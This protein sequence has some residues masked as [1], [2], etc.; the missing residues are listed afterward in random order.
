MRRLLVPALVLAFP[1]IAAGG[2]DAP[3]ADRVSATSSLAGR[4]TPNDRTLLT[5]EA[6]GFRGELGPA[7]VLDTSRCSTTSYWVL[8]VGGVAGTVP[9]SVT[10]GIRLSASHARRR[11]PCATGEPRRT[12][13]PDGDAYRRRPRRGRRSPQP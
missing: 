2:N 4:C 13:V 9:C 12:P 11:E 5:G 1:F 10:D 7:G 6:E 3:R 8:G